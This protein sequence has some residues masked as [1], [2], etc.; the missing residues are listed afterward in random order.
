[1]IKAHL[2]TIAIFIG[3]I[4][5]LVGCIYYP[6]FGHAALFAAAII[7]VSLMYTGIYRSIRNR[8]KKD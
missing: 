2:L 8:F 5:I 1:M 7:Y 4:G 6:S 3:I